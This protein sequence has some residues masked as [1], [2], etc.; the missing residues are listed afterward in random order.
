V[1]EKSGISL[2]VEVFAEGQL[3]EGMT[4]VLQGGNPAEIPYE[5][6]LIDRIKNDDHNLFY[7]LIQPY[8]RRVYAAALAILKNEADAEDI[9]QDSTLNA[10]AGIDTPYNGNAAAFFGRRGCESVRSRTLATG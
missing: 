5:A 9:V 2:R 6:E 1:E 8:E 7:Q 10:G 4:T 3:S